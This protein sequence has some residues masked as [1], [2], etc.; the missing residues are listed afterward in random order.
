MQYIFLQISSFQL[1][2]LWISLAKNQKLGL[3]FIE[4]QM[5]K[6]ME[7]NIYNSN[8]IKLMSMK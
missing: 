4:D 1:G 5:I 6:E 3:S 8:I 7:D 2:K